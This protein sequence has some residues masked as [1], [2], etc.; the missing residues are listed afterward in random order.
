M[1][2]ATERIKDKL[3]FK[4]SVTMTEVEECF[5]NRDGGLFEDIRE[6][7]KTFPPTQWFISE[8]NVGRVV[9]YSHH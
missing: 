7:N 2:Y 1:I 3:W 8:T 9:T 5:Y 6:K 4:H